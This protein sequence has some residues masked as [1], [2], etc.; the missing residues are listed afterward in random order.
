MEFLVGTTP[1]RVGQNPISARLFNAHTP[2]CSNC[3]DELA[4]V[5]SATPLL[6]IIGAMAVFFLI[7]LTTQRF[8]ASRARPSHAAPPSAGPERT[9]V[10]Q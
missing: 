4:F 10:K 9:A 2:A 8:G 7:S 5:D 6:T 1:P 3:S